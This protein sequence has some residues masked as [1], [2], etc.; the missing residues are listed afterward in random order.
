M[1]LCSLIHPACKT[2]APYFHLWSAPFY[3]IF[4]HYLTEATIFGKKL[5]NTQFVFRFSEQRFSDIFLV[6]RVIQIDI[7]IIHTSPCKVPLIVVRFKKKTNF[8]DRFSKNS[9]ISY[10]NSSSVNRAVSCGQTDRHNE[11]NSRFSTFAKAFSKT[12]GS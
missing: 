4:P 6:L 1:C 8:L 9:Q 10:E 7:I 5:F 2:H 11:A 3:N 12:K